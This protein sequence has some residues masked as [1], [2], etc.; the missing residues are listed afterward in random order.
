MQEI[1]GEYRYWLPG[2]DNKIYT[3]KSSTNSVIV[4]GANGSGKSKLG[5]WIEQQDCENVHRI[6]AQRSINF[7]ERVP[8]KSYAEAEENVFYGNP[9]YRHNKDGR[10][11]FGKQLTTKL[12]DDFDDVLAALISKVHIE[13]QQFVDACKK[14]EIERSNRPDLPITTLDK[15]QQIWDQIFPQRGIGQEDAAFYAFSKTNQER[16]SATQM[17]DGERSVLYLAAQ[18]LCIPDSKIIIMDEPEVHLHPSLMGQLWKSLELARPD[19]LFI[20]IT[21]DVRFA[22]SHSDS[23][24]VWVKSYDG[25]NW[26]IEYLPETDLPKDLLIQ[27]LGN[28]KKVLFVEGEEGGTDKRVYSVL[29]PDCNVIPS[30]GCEQVVSNVR[31]Y[32]RTDSLHDMEAWG[33]I[34]RDYKSEDQLNAYRDSG[35]WSLEVAEIENLFITE[36]V[37]RILAQRLSVDEESVL[38]D[39]KNYV[40]NRFEAQ[41]ASQISKAIISRTKTSLSAIEIDEGM[42]LTAG[43][44][45][46]QIDIKAIQKEVETTYITALKNRNH[47]EILTLFNDK[48]LVKSVGRFFGLDNKVYVER[49]IS[50]LE[51]DLKNELGRALMKYVNPSTLPQ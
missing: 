14:A 24:T 30:G 39:V 28:R 50:L 2:P 41:L 5:A 23:D 16:Y 51:G 46:N 48:S 6:A 8:M 43:A 34:D 7:S 47:D 33:I 37:V 26:E 22:S 36:D 31:S 15:L 21:H 4:I 38:G 49:I 18:V 9:T 20:Y 40:A 25:T 45:I 10:W 11:G 13:N 44:I 27:L 29:F 1:K 32:N 35:V 12:L 3:R 42:Q 19:C 17:S